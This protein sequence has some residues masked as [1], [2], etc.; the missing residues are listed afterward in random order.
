MFSGEGAKARAHDPCEAAGH[1]EAQRGKE[2]EDWGTEGLLNIYNLRKN[3]NARQTFYCNFGKKKNP[4]SSF[5]F[6][7]KTI[8]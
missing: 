2:E 1:Q 4:K 3:K 7:Y 8:W 6:G 5:L